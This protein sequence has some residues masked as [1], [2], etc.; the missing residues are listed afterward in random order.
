[1]SPRPRRL[2]GTGQGLTTVLEARDFT[3]LTMGTIIVL[4]S[5]ALA[6]VDHAKFAVGQSALT[7]LALPLLITAL[8]LR[9]R[10]VAR[11][12][13]ISAM[14]LVC[15]ST[16]FAS[17]TTNARIT[18]SVLIF[19]VCSFGLVSLNGRWRWL[20]LAAAAVLWSVITPAVP[21]PIAV[22]DVVVNARWLTLLQLL[23]AGPWL[24]IAWGAELD[25]IRLRDEIAESRLA[26]LLASIAYRERLRVWREQLTHIHETVLNDI[27]SVLDSPAVDWRR[28]RSQVAQRTPTAP[29]SQPRNT[30]EAMLEGIRDADAW[31]DALLIGPMAELRLS[32]ERA[33][34]LRAVLLELIR[35]L[36]RHSGATQISAFSVQEARQVRILLRHNGQTDAHRGAA[37]IGLGVIVHDAIPALQGTLELSE[38]TT[39][40]R[41][42]QDPP[43]QPSVT[44]LHPDTWRVVLATGAAGNAIG[45]SGHYLLM[46]LAYGTPGMLMAACAFIT[47]A[48]ATAASWQRRALSPVVMIVASTTAALVPLLAS[49]MISTCSRAGLPIVVSTLSSIG[50]AA[51]VV[52]AP[53]P[54]WMWLI[55]GSALGM[56][57][58]GQTARDACAQ[59]ATPGLLAALAAPVFSAV[60]FAGLR[61]SVQ[62]QR[63]LDDER[64]EAVRVSAAV[65]AARDFGAALHEAVDSATELL[66]EASRS[67][68]L[69][70]ETRMRLRC[71]DAEIR[72]SIQ[73]DPETAGTFARVGR[74]LVRHACEQ[75]IPVRVLALRDSGDRRPLPDDVL[76]AM[77]QLLAA[78]TEG[79]ASV[80]ALGAPGQDTLVISTSQRAVL[81]T[82]LAQAWSVSFTDGMADLDASDPAAPAT[83]MV[84]RSVAL[85]V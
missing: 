56:L 24:A 49:S 43:E 14:V 36:R 41:I 42:P 34:T 25:R 38:D 72:A 70:P 9:G 20:W 67:E 29:P 10:D 58:L 32:D 40:L 30:I 44:P 75:G 17:T 26:N 1:M 13:A 78:S 19:M 15:A 27:R 65:T 73:V 66:R 46:A 64:S 11:W 81:R 45:G 47:A 69:T 31:G 83:L 18:A 68:S 60:V 77:R 74:E 48:V 23:V 63:G 51:V 62:Q 54:R 85:D 6:L 4:S 37:G 21:L 53:S 16:I 55:A 3:I 57:H 2:A 84:Q 61:W 22:G 28:L 71:R 33:S 80:Q 12:L 5:N 52:W 59:A 79:D 50:A 76:D 82:G 7:A 35:N 8:L 39:S